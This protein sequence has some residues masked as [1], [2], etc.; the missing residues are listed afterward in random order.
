VQSDF[1]GRG[2]SFPLEVNV[3]GGVAMVGGARKLE[4]AMTLVLG[5]HPGERP[6]RPAFGC[7]LR[8]HVFRGTGEQTRNE[9]ARD[10]RSSLEMWEPR[11]VVTDVRV[12]P[13]PND[14]RL[15]LIDIDY[16]TKAEND[17]RNLVFPFYTIPEEGE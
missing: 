17:P 11:V 4:Q 14:E 1:V 6:F 12:Y 2:W 9:I 13:H 7:P 3:N 5:T 15:L 16:R 10:V 8:N